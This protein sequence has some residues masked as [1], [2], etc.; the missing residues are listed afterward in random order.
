MSLATTIKRS[1]AV[2]GAICA[3]WII[4]SVVFSSVI[5]IG[6][7]VQTVSHDGQDAMTQTAVAFFNLSPKWMITVILLSLYFVIYFIKNKKLVEKW[8]S[9]FFEKFF[10]E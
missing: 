9:R 8:F 2:I 4:F 3:A 1:L 5:F 6:S 10:E 7:F